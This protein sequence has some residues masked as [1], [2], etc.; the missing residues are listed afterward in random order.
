MIEFLEKIYKRRLVKKI[1]RQIKTFQAG[2]NSE[3]L[4]YALKPQQQLH[5]LLLK[6]LKTKDKI[7]VAFFVVHGSVWKLDE[8]YRLMEADE[9]FEPIIVIIPYVIF[10][11]QQMQQDMRLAYNLFLAK[12]YQV[13]KTWNEE[14][15]TWLDIKQNINPDIIFYT[16]PHELTKPEYYIYHFPDVLSCYVQYSF[17]I[18]HLHEMQ[19]NQPFHNFLWRAFYETAMHRNFAQKYATN[20]GSNVTVVG[21]AGTDVFLNPPKI[22]ADPWKIK[23]RNVKRIIWAPHHTIDDDK[24]FLSYSS[25]LLYADFFLEIADKYQSSIQFAFKPHPILRPKLSEENVWGKDKTDAY[26]AQWDSEKNMQL[27]E[28]DYT[29]LFLTS[30]AL[31]HDSASFMV[32]YLYL[33]K[34][35]LYTLRDDHVTDRFNEFGRLAFQVHQHAYNTT[36]ILQFLDDTV[37]G[38]NDIKTEER[39]TFYKNYLI[40]PNHSTASANI[41]SEITRF[42]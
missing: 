30:D 23:D 21:Y 31:I 19:Y 37:L 9:R 6:H 27:F 35:T 2:I 12:G 33:D 14:T 7:K 26:Y 24:S 10:G 3:R 36:A 41:I 28:A 5:Q 16:N 25:F 32:E 42:I 13:V 34:P 17:H 4:N 39:K 40:P 8:V 22:I 11:E 29:D 38:E 18:T 1:K 20:K 15:N